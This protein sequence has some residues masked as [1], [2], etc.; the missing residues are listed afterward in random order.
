MFHQKPGKPPLNFEELKA[1]LYHQREN[2]ISGKSM[3]TKS[4]KVLTR[5]VDDPNSIALSSITE[6]A[7]ANHVNASTITRLAK[8]LGYRRFRQLQ[9][10]L[11]EHVFSQLN[12]YSKQAQTIL[13]KSSDRPSSDVNLGLMRKIITVEIHNIRDILENVDEKR[14][15]EC[16]QLIA[17]ARSVR[18]LGLRQCFSIAHFFSYTLK[19]IRDQVSILG[20]GGHALAEDIAE[21]HQDDIVLIITVKPYSTDVVSAYEA[22]SKRGVKIVALTDSHGSPVVS[23]KASCFIVSTQGPFYFNSLAATLVFLE[24]LLV[25]VARQ[26]GDKAINTLKTRESLFKELKVEID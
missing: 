7:R 9:D 14:F 1:F 26:L 13:T 23:N 20:E 10:I 3:G 18:I 24:S 8:R 11:R 17:R 6:I 22:L 12:F 4:L 2:K 15:L 21:L 5:I 19:L 25:I 16:A